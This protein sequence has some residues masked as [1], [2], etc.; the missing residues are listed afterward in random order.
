MIVVRIISGLGNQL[1]QYAV[2]RQL[3]LR[4][5]T[6]LLLDTA[7]YGN[8]RLRSFQLEHFNIPPSVLHGKG[9][10]RLG[11]SLFRK[12]PFVHRAYSKS[13]Q[14]FFGRMK[15]LISEK[16]D[17]LYDERV[18]AVKKHAY[19]NGY[20]QN[21]RYFSHFPPAIRRELTVKEAQLTS[22]QKEIDE[23][24]ANRFSTSLHIRRGDYVTNSYMAQLMGVQPLEYYQKAIDVIRQEIKQPF[25]YVFSDD[26][27]WAKDH[28]KWDGPTRFIDVENGTKDYLELDLMRRCRHNIIANSSFSWWGAFLNENPDKIV[29]APRRWVV[30]ES[31]NERIEIC[32]PNWTRI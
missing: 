30:P 10:L 25:L 11:L 26:L 6:S 12:H 5:N 13:Q 21:W 7:F 4:N 22:I 14:L 18:D 16:E 8:H 19:L 15:K 17:W 32:F 27:N 24:S 3:S 23:I 9:F 28:L 29:V 2:G 1:F 31:I 20:W